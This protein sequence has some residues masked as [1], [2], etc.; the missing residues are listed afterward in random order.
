MKVSAPVPVFVNPK[1]PPFSLMTP[2]SVSWAPSI[3]TLLLALSVTGPAK[4]L[5]P[6]LVASVPPFSVTASNVL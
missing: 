1:D 2:A 4:V 6:V 5:V 3:T